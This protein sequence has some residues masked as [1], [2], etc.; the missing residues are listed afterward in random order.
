MH[1]I[2]RPIASYFSDKLWSMQI[3]VYYAKIPS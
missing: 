3:G 2:V 1:H